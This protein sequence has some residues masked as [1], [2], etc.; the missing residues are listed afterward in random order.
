VLGTGSEGGASK[1]GEFRAAVRAGRLTTTTSRS[2]DRPGTAAVGDR[3]EWRDLRGRVNWRRKSFLAA[4]DGV[5]P[6]LHMHRLNAYDAEGSRPSGPIG[7][8]RDLAEEAIGCPS[9][10]RIGSKPVST[11]VLGETG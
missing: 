2:P 11:V 5:S 7:W 3:A 8:L 6:G 1:H 10:V 4:A 9:G